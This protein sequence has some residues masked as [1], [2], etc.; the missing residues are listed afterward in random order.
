MK[1]SPE[2]LHAYLSFT[3]ET[4]STNKY[5]DQA[6][7]TIERTLLSKQISEDTLERQA[8]TLATQL[9]LCL[10]ASVLIRRFPQQVSDAFC[11]ARLGPD[12]GSVF[13]D[14]PREVNADS[15]LPRLP[16]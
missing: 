10:Q 16:A 12:R 14:L 9:A 2:S 15:L 8:R 11:A 4:K 3:R 7:Q 1:K 5:Y 6:L 13:G